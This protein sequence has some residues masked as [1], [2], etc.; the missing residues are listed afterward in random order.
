[1][2]PLKNLMSGSVQKA[3]IGKQLEAN[4][5]VEGSEKVLLAIFGDGSDKDVRPLYFKNRTLTVSCSSSVF[6]QEIK[7]NE[8]DII[9]KITDE[10]GATNVERIRYLL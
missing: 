5:I 9:E 3:G 6:A 1:M 7:L 8:K 4:K 2:Q 10:T